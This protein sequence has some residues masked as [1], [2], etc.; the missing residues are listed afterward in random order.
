MAGCYSFALLLTLAT[1]AL[2]AAAD[3]YKWVD[4][5]GVV[6]Y[7][8]NPPSG[9]GAKAQVVEERISI[10]PPDPSLGPAVAAMNARAARQAQYDEADWQQ[11]QRY[12]AMAQ[13]SYPNVYG[14]YGMG[15]D[16]YAVPYYPGYAPAFLIRNNRFVSPQFGMAAH[17]AVPPR[18]GMQPRAAHRRPPR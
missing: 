9:I 4:A 18:A 13:T 17:V 15:Y 7:S 16:P 14:A 12:M 1:A 10:V 8:N 6:N 11:R 5:K 3:T 2:P